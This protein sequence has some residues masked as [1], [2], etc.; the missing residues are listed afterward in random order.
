MRIQPLLKDYVCLGKWAGEPRVEEPTF[1]DPDTVM[2][3]TGKRPAPPVKV[4]I[5][6]TPRAFHRY[7]ELWDAYEKLHGIAEAVRD[8]LRGAWKLLR[9]GKHSLSPVVPEVDAQG[10]VRERK[11]LFSR[12]IEG[13]DVE[14]ARIRECAVCKQIFWA[15]RIDAQQCGAA[16]CKTTLSSRLNRNPELRELYNKARRRKRRKQKEAQEKA[17]SLT[18]KRK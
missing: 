9:L 18:R 8:P 5:P 10:M 17:Q 4:F 2:A 15:G 16:K 11:N 12:A 14:A 3:L 7:S 6:V 13:Q 1:I